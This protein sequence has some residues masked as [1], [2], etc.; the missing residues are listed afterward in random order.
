MKEFSLSNQAQPQERFFSVV[1][2]EL[3]DEWLLNY[4]GP[5][6]GW[7]EDLDA[8]ASKFEAVDLELGQLIQHLQNEIG[9]T[10][11]YLSEPLVLRQESVF[12]GLSDVLASY[13]ERADNVFVETQW[14][15]ELHQAALALV[16]WSFEVRQALDSLDPLSRVEHVHYLVLY[17]RS[18]LEGYIDYPELYERVQGLEGVFGAQY[19][20]LSSL[21]V[22]DGLEEEGELL[23]ELFEEQV[24]AFDSLL[25]ACDESNPE[26]LA[27]ECDQLVL[28]AENLADKSDDFLAKAEVI[29]RE[30]GNSNS[31]EVSEA[32]GN[33]WEQYSGFVDA[34]FA[35]TQ[36]PLTSETQ[37]GM[38]NFYRYLSASFDSVEAHLDNL[39]RKEEQKDLKESLEEGIEVARWL[40]QHLSHSLN[41][42]PVEWEKVRRGEQFLQLI[43]R[44][45]MARLAESQTQSDTY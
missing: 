38:E 27:K 6:T 20:L 29:E 40:K 17:V 35:M 10:Q 24:A 12:K 26:K 18:C 31:F 16:E 11:M 25:L 36:T 22:I 37:Q 21:P 41:G 9:Y 44:E 14:L 15:Q 8:V 30:S 3:L 2:I 45:L 4:S 32:E 42:N 33:G 28:I 39:I 34:W 43:F 7:S 1:G 5:E 19:R 23:E 13:V